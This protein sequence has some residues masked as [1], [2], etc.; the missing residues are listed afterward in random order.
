M[1]YSPIVGQIRRQFK[2]RFVRSNRFSF[3]AAKPAMGGVE[4]VVVVEVDPATNPSPNNALL[5]N[6]SFDPDGS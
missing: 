3:H 6:F 1:S 5:F 2:L 4:P